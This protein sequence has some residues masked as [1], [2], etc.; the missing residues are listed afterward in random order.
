MRITTYLLDFKRINHAANLVLSSIWGDRS[1]GRMNSFFTSQRITKPV[2]EELPC[3][4][5]VM[6]FELEPHYPT[7]LV[8][9]WVKLE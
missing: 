8:R 2:D 3:Q 5:R 7:Y 1:E 4:F 6:I 9:A